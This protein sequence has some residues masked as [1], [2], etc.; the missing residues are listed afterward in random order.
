[1]KKLNLITRIKSVYPTITASEK[2]CADLILTKP[3]EMGHLTIKELAAQVEVSLPT[4]VRFARRLGFEG[5]KDF[6]VALIRDVATGYFVSP[7]GARRKGKTSTIHMIFEQEMANLRETMMNLDEAAMHK[8]VKAIAGAE[9]VLLFAVSSSLPIAIDLHWK[10]SIAGFTSVHSLD[11]YTQQLNAKNSRPDDV[12]VGISF[13]GA[14]RDVVHCM[15]SAQANGTRTI[16]VTSFINSAITRHADIKLFTAPVQSSHQAIDLPSRT[17]QLVLL[18][19]LFFLI[20][21]Q[22]VNRISRIIT[23]AEADLQLRRLS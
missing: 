15:A 10:L 18:D 20:V 2:R 19:A 13:S 9:R 21:Q 7:D 1:M 5:F 17:S 22:D 23:R 4:V 6:K 11:V 3:E 8:A 16:C 14:S 12:A